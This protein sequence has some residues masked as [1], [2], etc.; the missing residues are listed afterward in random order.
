MTRIRLVGQDRS[1]DRVQIAHAA[2]AHRIDHL[3]PDHREAVLAAER[4]LDAESEYGKAAEE[5]LWTWRRGLAGVWMSAGWIK[6][7]NR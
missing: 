4:Y 1:S 7:A 2:R 6:G 3:A 5:R